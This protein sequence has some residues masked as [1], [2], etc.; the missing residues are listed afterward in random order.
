[1]PFGREVG[2]GPGDIVLDGDSG[3]TTEGGTAAPA[4][5]RPMS[6]VAKRTPISAT[7]E[8]FLCPVRVG[9]H[10]LIRLIRLSTFHIFGPGS[11]ERPMTK[12][13]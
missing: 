8:L 13:F 3:P 9:L 2:L 10:S 12:L 4:T 11:A 6:I 7:A 5:I 1:M